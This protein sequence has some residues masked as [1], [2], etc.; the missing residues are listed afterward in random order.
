MCDQKPQ[1]KSVQNQ[2]VLDSDCTIGKFIEQMMKLEKNS[3][4]ETNKDTEK[5]EW[6]AFFKDLCSEYT[7]ILNKVQS[8]Q[9]FRD[10]RSCTATGP[11][12]YGR[13]VTRVGAADPEL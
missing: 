5:A 13:T 1:I 11:V 6:L 4:M 10:E 7:R 3:T 12:V 2:F 9:S 8:Y